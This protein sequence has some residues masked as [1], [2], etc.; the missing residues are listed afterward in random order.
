MDLE[1]FSGSV[2]G[3][4]ALAHRCRS[5]GCVGVA[6][7][8]LGRLP[9]SCIRRL[10][11]LALAFGLALAGCGDG[12]DEPP[13][14]HRRDWLP[15]ARPGDVYDTRFGLATVVRGHT[16][17]GFIWI[18]HFH[19]CTDDMRSL[20]GGSLAGFDPNLYLSMPRAP[21]GRLPAG[22]WLYRCG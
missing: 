16:A 5:R 4:A 13:S 15:V 6:E 2:R 1:K 17:G 7:P 3:T 20:G 21:A 14:A 8:A 11:T 18:L 12:D 10:L 19:D 22:R 9:Y